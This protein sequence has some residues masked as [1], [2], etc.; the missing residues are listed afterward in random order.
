MFLFT[1]F[2]FILLYQRTQRP[3]RHLTGMDAS[4]RFSDQDGALAFSTFPLLV[5]ARRIGPLQGA[6][7][8]AGGDGPGAHDPTAW[9]VLLRLFA[10]DWS[11][12]SC[13]LL[14]VSE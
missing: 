4:R 6:H 14:D 5:H 1:A 2:L 9:L 8:R 12:E 3:N 11:P 7:A 10:R 13:D